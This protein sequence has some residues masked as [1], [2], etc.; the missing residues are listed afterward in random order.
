[1]TNYK[2]PVTL[3]Q[4]ALTHMVQTSKCGVV[5]AKSNLSIPCQ[6]SAREAVVLLNSALGSVSPDSFFD[7][8]G[9]GEVTYKG[10]IS[11][12]IPQLLVQLKQSND[13]NLVE[14][15][16]KVSFQESNRRAS[17]DIIEKIKSAKLDSYCNLSR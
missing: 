8:T 13:N 6:N 15:Q 9:N 3:A 1:M 16:S 7:L 14:Q 5:T 12:C 4:M 2:D 17:E 11:L 10:C